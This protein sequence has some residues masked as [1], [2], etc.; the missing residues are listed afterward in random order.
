MGPT[1]TSTCDMC[2]LG[3]RRWCRSHVRLKHADINDKRSEW[4]AS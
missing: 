2:L 1:R 4:P 3:L